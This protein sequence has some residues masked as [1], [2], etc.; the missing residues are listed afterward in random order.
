MIQNTQLFHSED[1]ANKTL[2]VCSQNLS[3]P[4]PPMF[5]PLWV[6]L[7]GRFELTSDWVSVFH[8]QTF[9]V[10]SQELVLV[11]S[12]SEMIT[13]SYLSFFRKHIEKK[14]K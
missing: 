11:N 12:T 10:F 4:N 5:M 14:S 3:E 1:L 7:C 6:G 13:Y 8:L 9:N 2:K